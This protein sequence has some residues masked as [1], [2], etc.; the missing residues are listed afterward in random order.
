MGRARAVG[1]IGLG[2]LAGGVVGAAAALLL[3]PRAGRET[4]EQVRRAADEARGKI[5]GVLEESRQAVQES[6]TA[7]RKAVEAGRGVLQGTREKVEAAPVA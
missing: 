7:L 1:I 6:R 2:L 3:A 5:R 4:R